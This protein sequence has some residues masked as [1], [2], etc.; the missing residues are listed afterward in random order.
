MERAAQG[1]G[2]GPECQS[3]R[4]VWPWLSDRVWDSSDALWSQE[5]D[6]LVRLLSDPANLGYSMILFFLL[7][8]WL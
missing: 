7:C 8:I 4:R 6:S 1:S 5:L 2:Y 3:A